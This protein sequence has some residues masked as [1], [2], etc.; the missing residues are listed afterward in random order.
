MAVTE[1]SCDFSLVIISVLEKCFGI[2]KLKD[3]LLASLKAAVAVMPNNA[4][5]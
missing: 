3:K 4:T 1:K 5:R 2:D